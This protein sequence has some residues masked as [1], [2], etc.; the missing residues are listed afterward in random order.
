MT[1]RSPLIASA[2]AALVSATGAVAAPLPPA[3]LAQLVPGGEFRGF[4]NRGA[5]FENHIWRFAPDGSVRA[6]YTID[7][8]NSFGN[9]REEGADIGRWR[10]QGDRVC[11]E[12]ARIL[13][14][15]CYVVDAGPPPNV[16]LI[17]PPVLEGTFSR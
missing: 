9:Y 17:G 10:L 11:I 12:W 4:F 13:P 2:F 15:A 8:H 14:P 1:S 3:A 7:R 6:V 5:N 16:R